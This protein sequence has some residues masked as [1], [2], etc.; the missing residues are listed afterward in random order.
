[1]RL[2]YNDNKIGIYLNIIKLILLYLYLLL[3]VFRRK[4]GDVEDIDCGAKCNAS[5]TYIHKYLY[6]LSVLEKY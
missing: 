3:T 2:S 5:H 4:K 1:M 6:E